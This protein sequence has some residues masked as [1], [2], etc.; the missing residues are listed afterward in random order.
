MK[1]TLQIACALIRQSLKTDTAM[2]CILGY[3]CNVFPD[4]TAADAALY[5]TC[6]CTC[7][8]CTRRGC[9]LN[10]VRGFIFNTRRFVHNVVP[11]LQMCDDIGRSMEP[12]TSIAQLAEH[13]VLGDLLTEIPN[14]AG[15][16][17]LLFDPPLHVFWKN[18]FCL[19]MK[20]WYESMI[21]KMDSIITLTTSSIF[22]ACMRRRCFVILEVLPPPKYKTFLQR[23][24]SARLSSSLV[25]KF[26]TILR[27]GRPFFTASSWCCIGEAEFYIIYID[28]KLL[29]KSYSHRRWYHALSKDGDLDW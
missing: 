16:F 13:Y 29:F 2:Y 4:Q 10:I 28:A 14:V 22:S 24:Q 1:V 15:T 11:A 26:H 25:Q 18:K 6:R 20:I 27:F 21:I 9:I 7:I 8:I 23:W 3:P 19:Q 12:H 5:R 17:T